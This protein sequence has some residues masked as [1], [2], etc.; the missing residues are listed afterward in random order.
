MRASIAAERAGVRSVSIVSTGFVGQGRVVAEAQGIPNL[1]I[2]EYPGVIMTDSKEELRKKVEGII[3]NNVIKGLSAAVEGTVTANPAEPSSRDIIFKGNLG[4]VNGF[5]NKNLWTDGLPIIP[6][7]IGNVQEFLRFTDRSPDEVIGVLLPENRESTIWNIAVNGVMAGCR[8]EYMS[9]L[10]SVVEAI[11]EPEFRI[12]DA[13]S[14]PGWEPL[15]IL[16]G[17]IIKELDFNYG[18]GVMRVGRQANTSIGRFLRLYMRNIAGLRI[19]PGQSDKGTMGYTF[20]VVLAENEDA[21]AE[22][23]WHPFSVDRGFKAGENVVTVQSVVCTSPPCYSAGDSARDHVETIAEIIGRRTAACWAFAA[24]IHGRFHPVLVISPA[25]ASVIANDG[26]AKDDVRQYL[27]D[28]V[29]TPAGLVEKMYWQS[30]GSSVSICAAVEAGITPKEYCESTDPNRLVP[31]FVRPEWIGIV[32]SG[33]PGRNQSKGY[34]QN[35]KQGPPVSK[36]IELPANWNQL[37][38]EFSEPS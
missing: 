31:V 29:K 30:S 16:N 26:W 38:K 22:L 37:L 9:I 32:V 14:T 33:D 21:V 4:E 7:T 5:F 15:I 28:Q 3:V 36:K 8:P 18:S 12:E 11:A 6:P 35:Q 2:V 20:N 24:A 23:G 27:Y 13:G 10:V 1:V 34:V 17:P 25:V 19:P